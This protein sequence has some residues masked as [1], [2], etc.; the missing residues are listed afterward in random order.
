MLMQT[1]CDFQIHSLLCKWSS[2]YLCAL[3]PPNNLIWTHALW[4]QK[5]LI[6]E[7]VTIN[8]W[9][10]SVFIYTYICILP[11]KSSKSNIKKHFSCHMEINWQSDFA[12]VGSQWHDDPSSWARSGQLAFCCWCSSV[13]LNI[14]NHTLPFPTLFLSL[15]LQF[16][17]SWGHSLGSC[18]SL[19][20]F[21][22]SWEKSNFKER[23]ETI[24]CN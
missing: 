17:T 8:H 24:P 23:D 14:P 12:S 7:N 13:F 4:T 15:L 22:I 9:H 2:V 19:Y 10:L 20:S 1:I 16:V 18:S 11:C 5:Q 6:L 21:I 3:S